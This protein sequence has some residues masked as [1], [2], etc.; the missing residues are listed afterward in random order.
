MKRFRYTVLLA[1]LAYL[2]VAD[3]SAE[4]I[5]FDSA[6]SWQ[7]WT[8]PLGAV[9]INENGHLI[10]VPV[11]KRTNA[12]E[13]ATR[14]GGGIR[15]VGSNAPMA[16]LLMDGD[17]T[18]A[19]H[20]RTEDGQEKWW[21]EIDLGR[22][23]IADEVRIQLAEEAAP[24]EFFRVFIS[25]G[26]PTF[27]N[28]LV[29]VPGT[30]VYGLSL[31]YG[32]N[33]AHELVIPLDRE[34]VRVLRIEAQE[35]TQG[36]GIA[37][38]TVHTPG[39]NIALG[40]IERGGSIEV[41]TDQQQ[42]LAGAERIADGDLVT[43]WAMTTYHQTES[44]GQEVFNR[45]TFDLGAHYWVNRIFIIGD[46]VGAP[47]SRRTQFNN[48][49][50]YQISVSDGSLAPDGSLRWEEVVFQPNLPENLNQIRRFDHSFDLRKIRYV[51][52]FFP[53]SQGGQRAPGQRFGLISEFQIYGEGT[54]AEVR[55]TSPLVDLA[56][57][58][59][60]TS[61]TWDNDLPSQTRMEVRSRTG[62]EI[63][64]E[65][66][67]FDKTG[68]EIT[69]RKWEKTPSSLRG[70]V[71]TTQVVGSGWS[72]WSDPYVASGSLFRSPSPRRYVQL[73]VWLMADD[74]SAVPS[75]SALRL[76][77]GNPM[78]V[79][80]SG[81]IA[82]PVVKPG[83][84]QEFTYFLRP[85]FDTASQGVDRL[86]L[87]ASVPVQFVGL[88]VG[89]RRVQGELETTD[90]GFAVMLPEKLQS[91]ELV[92]LAFRSTIYHN[93]TR[94]DLFLGNSA[95]GDEIRQRV[96]IGNAS[97]AVASET[98]SVSLPITS[99]LLSNLMLSSPVFTPNG[100]GIG[101][102]I[103]IEFDLLKLMTSRPVET[104]IYDL[105]GRRVRTLELL[106]ATAGH[107]ALSWDGR[108]ANGKLV[109]PGTYLLRIRVEGDSYAQVL[110]RLLAVAF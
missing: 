25:N 100:D 13:D 62:N 93:Q 44:A 78:A 104:G 86:W 72:S 33:E 47:T 65:Q 96:D 41:N 10:L 75:L 89:E 85:R 109:P 52:H 37:E 70:P 36:A 102:R 16:I 73:Q 24:L 30:I 59:N 74:P 15:G 5:S 4:Q 18:T 14:F 20:P 83:E 53:S 40:L 42:I 84:E 87:A 3:T 80:T 81:E 38:I 106:D 49:F 105:A 97:E 92:Q 6:A 71:E 67:Y 2:L 23:V 45:F 35:K 17:R 12:I 9:E 57:R 110:N 21:V 76:E 56:E 77:V 7:D 27:S 39:D 1:S 43:F 50:W 34:P 91:E 79:E 108:A 31:R 26:E 101:D 63:L 55:L 82:P 88:Q 98:V 95:L 11:R 8:M 51:R 103:E 60:I 66:Y 68:K 64:E 99:D 107:Y 22:V 32:F 19:W 46:P 29:P 69:Q 54:P 28:A 48:F 61:V 94:F 58:S 90:D